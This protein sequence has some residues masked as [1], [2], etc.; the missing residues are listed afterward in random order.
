[1]GFP[2]GL[3]L[4]AWLRRS[5]GVV[6]AVMIFVWAPP[7][8]GAAENAKLAVA[9]S[10]DR[11]GASTTI[12]VRFVISA[13]N[14]EV[15]SPVTEFALRLPPGMGF[16]TTTLGLA[17]CNTSVL[18]QIGP[19]ACSPNAFMGFGDAQ[20]ETGVGST[21]VRERID[22]STLMAPAADGHTAISFYAAGLTPLLA[23]LVFPGLLL[24][25]TGPGNRS[26][27]NLDMFIPPVAAWPGGPEAA[28]TSLTSSFGPNGLTYYRHLHGRTVPY[29]PSGPTVPVTCPRGGFALTGTFAF[30]DGTTVA[31]TAR[32]PCPRRRLR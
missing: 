26:Y 4:A 20:I 23:G 1:M 16:A 18:E 30:E 19:R 25:Q 7:V 2:C 13:T 12:L 31:P 32:V 3:W 17:V 22:I 14:G 24:P 15:P 6:G 5:V 11:L 10:P 21:L 27:I 9:F 29:R 28:I 8:S